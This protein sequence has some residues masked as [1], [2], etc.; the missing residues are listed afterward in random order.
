MHLVVLLVVAVSKILASE[1]DTSSQLGLLCGW[2]VTGYIPELCDGLDP[3]KTG[4]PQGY[5]KLIAQGDEVHSAVCVKAIAD[6]EPGKSGTWCGLPGEFV[7][8]GDASIRGCPIGYHEHRSWNW[9]F[10][11]DSKSNDIQ[12]T[13]CGISMGRAGWEPDLQF[14]CGGMPSVNQCPAPFRAFLWQKHMPSC[15]YLPQ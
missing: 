5:T 13:L 2:S 6:D 3:L 1:N 9:C 12:G 11:D 14:S 15:F 8:C 10:K 7:S 4:C